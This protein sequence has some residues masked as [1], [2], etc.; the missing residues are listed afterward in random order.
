MLVGGLSILTCTAASSIYHLYGCMS[1]DIYYLLL[2]IDLIGIGINIFGL[3]LAAVYIGF[4]N[5]HLYRN[6]TMMVM[7]TL[8][9]GNLVIQ[10]TPCYAEER[11][12]VH[13]IVFYCFATLI[14]L[15]LAI[16]GRFYLATDLEVELFYGMLERSFAYLFLGFWFYLKK[17]PEC[18]FRQEW[19]Q[20]FLNSHMWWHLLVFAN[21]YTL[22]WLA[23]DFNVHVEKY[24]DKLAPGDELTMNPLVSQLQ[25]N[26]PS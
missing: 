6:Y 11:F 12:N 21:G 9:V 14:C 23:F 5:W 4:H 15:G 10:M 24:W 3:T 19:V 18:Y 17:F 7:A 22:Y 2:K 13:R 25:E 1:K 8:M 20:L 26:L 16:L